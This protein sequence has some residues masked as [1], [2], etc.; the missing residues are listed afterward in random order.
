MQVIRPVSEGDLDDLVELARHTSFGLTTLP[1]DRSFLQRRIRRSERAFAMEA[2]EPP[3]G[4]NY[5]LVLA[6][7]ETDR[8]VGT[9]GVISKVGGFEPFYAYQLKTHLHASKQLGVRKE[10]RTLNLLTEHDG[11]SEIGSLFLHPDAR[12]PGAGRALSLSRFLL[13]ARLPG[14]FEGTVLAE[15]RGVIDAQGGSVFWDAVGRHFF[16]LDFPTAD[17][18]SLVSKQFIAELMPVHPLY[19]P[20]LPQVAQAVIGRVHDRT[21]PALRILEREGF[22]ATELV[23]IF[24]AGPMVQCARDEIRAVRESRVAEV[25]AVTAEGEPGEGGDFVVSREAPPF[26]ACQARVKV[27]ETGA[28]SLSR[29]AAGALALGVGDEVRFVALRPG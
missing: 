20:L 19:V 5:L 10:V 9:A 27:T 8:V 23:D 29:E 6:E 12:R 25:G 2:D 4:E 3:G 13:M 7:A 21:A 1:R 28:V 17:Y 11:P 18:L 16:D 15:M 26:R 24:E 22:Q 14:R